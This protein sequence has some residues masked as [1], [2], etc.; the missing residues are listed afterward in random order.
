MREKERIKYMKKR[1]KG[2]LSAKLVASMTPREH[3]QIKKEW[4]KRAYTYRSKKKQ[5]QQK[6]P[7]NSYGKYTPAFTY[8]CSTS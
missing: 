1:E 4:K 7:E 3:R 2:K 5:Q 6:N 8:H